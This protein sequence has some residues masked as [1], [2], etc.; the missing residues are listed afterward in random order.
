MIQ[1]NTVAHQYH[2]STQARS[3]EKAKGE[4]EGEGGKNE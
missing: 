4:G 3:V 2:T 1:H